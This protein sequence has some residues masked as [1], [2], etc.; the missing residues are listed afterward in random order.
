MVFAAESEKSQSSGS[1][2]EAAKKLIFELK[3]G[4]NANLKS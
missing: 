2:K 4:K 3:S 1:A